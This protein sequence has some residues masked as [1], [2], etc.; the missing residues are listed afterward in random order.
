MGAAQ[1]SGGGD[2]ETGAKVAKTC[3][4]ELLGLSKDATDTEYVH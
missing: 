3:F 2:S 1:S 4:Y